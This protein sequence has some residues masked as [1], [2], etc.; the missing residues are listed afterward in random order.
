MLQIP[1]IINLDK[2]MKLIIF[3]QSFDKDLSGF[4]NLTGLICRD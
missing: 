1:R 4:Q 2:G 3:N